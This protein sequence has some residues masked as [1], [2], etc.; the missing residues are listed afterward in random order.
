MAFTLVELLMVIG[1]IGILIAILLPVVGKARASAR[2]AQCGS[3]LRQVGVGLVR[4]FND[5]KHLPART[6]VLEVANPHVFKYVT[7]PDSVA[8]S[9]EQYVGSR[10]VLYCPAN[11]LSRNVE[12]WWP[13][14]S[15]TIAGTY[16]YPFWLRNSLWMIAK[17]DYQ[18]LTSDRLLAADY[19]GVIV[20]SD[21]QVHVVAWN[22]ELM[23]DGA[24][25]GMNMLFGDGHVEWRRS[26]NRWQ[27]YG[28]GGAFVYWFYAN[29]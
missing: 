26:E 13:Y 12:S 2:V 24:P 6:G 7:H 5:F 27:V 8:E 9:M 10:Q 28:F 23:P 20:T 22:H 14:T 17:P 4:Y 21:T 16:Q 19:L 11:T 1:I 15:G 25:A 3:N 18:K 29:P